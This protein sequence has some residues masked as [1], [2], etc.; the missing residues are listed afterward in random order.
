MSL[1]L[2]LIINTAVVK[3]DHPKCIEYQEYLADGG[4]EM[5]AE[6]MIEYLGVICE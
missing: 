4:Y 5:D 1:I 2:W 6:E 3:P